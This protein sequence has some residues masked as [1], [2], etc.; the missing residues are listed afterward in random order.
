M[1]SLRLRST[2]LD[3]HGIADPYRYARWTLESYQSLVELANDENLVDLTELHV[4]AAYRRLDESSA[5][6]FFGE[7]L[8]VSASVTSQ[9][10]AALSLLALFATIPLSAVGRKVLTD[11]ERNAARTIPD[12]SFRAGPDGSSHWTV[13]L[14]KGTPILV[15]VQ[16]LDP[17]LGSSVIAAAIVLFLWA[18]EGEVRH[19]LLAGIDAL[20]Q[21][22]EYRIAH[23]SQMPEDLSDL[24]P[25]GEGGIT[26]TSQKDYRPDDRFPTLLIHEKTFLATLVRKEGKTP[27]LLM[28]LGF[29]LSEF[30]KKVLSGQIESAETAPKIAQLLR[31]AFL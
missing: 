20:Q 3:A 22:V 1:Q 9:R 7:L 23:R 28:L 10:T 4:E 26:M 19:D 11:S 16:A 5:A 2:E 24:I 17:S 12:L 29:V 13:T 21:K 6:V 31:H 14:S 30:T 25:A 8:K 15:V 27:G 18:F